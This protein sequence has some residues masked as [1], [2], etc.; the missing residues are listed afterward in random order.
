MQ[1]CLGTAQFGFDYGITNSKGKVSLTDVEEI[2]KQ[3]NSS[4][5]KFIDTAQNY[6]ESEINIGKFINSKLSFKVITK[7]DLKDVDLSSIY[8]D[9][10]LELKLQKSLNNLNLTSLEAILIHDSDIL[11]NKYSFKLIE[12]LKKIKSKKIINKF[13]LS[14]YDESE[15]SFFPI[16]YFDIVQLPLS[17]YDQRLRENGTL[18]ILKSNLIEIH[19]RS[20]F[21]QGLILQE[22]SKWPSFL[23]PNFIN[24]HKKVSLIAKEINFTLLDLSLYFLT[25]YI[26]AEIVLMG[27][28]SKKELIEIVNSL[29]KINL[30][31]NYDLDFKS[32]SWN[33]SL[34]IDPRKWIQN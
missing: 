20:I 19:L 15:L 16:N 33:D 11:K 18:E 22:Y 28:T 34:D 9:E 8:F 2:L 12:W 32:L 29:E 4:G 27:I 24:H 21:L 31:S 5:I 7:L 1:I 13:G 10:I 23:N 26:N 14:I 30:I 6:E 17:I 25:K 3:A